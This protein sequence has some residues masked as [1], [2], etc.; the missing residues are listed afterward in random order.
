MQRGRAADGCAV[1]QQGLQQTAY[2]QVQSGH[3]RQMLGGV[4]RFKAFE[5]EDQSGRGNAGVW[6]GQLVPQAREQFGMAMFILC[7][8]VQ[9]GPKAGWHGGL[10]RVSKHVRSRLFATSEKG[11]QVSEVLAQAW[12]QPLRERAGAHL[13]GDT[14]A[15][16]RP[17]QPGRNKTDWR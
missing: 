4:R 6:T 12:A 11:Q 5:K 2:S 7:N 1:A 16:R 8:L 9:T 15:G 17:R 13:G 10:E 3:A 14:G